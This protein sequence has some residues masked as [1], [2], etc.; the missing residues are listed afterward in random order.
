MKRL[1]VVLCVV[2][3]SLAL[4]AQM[5]QVEFKEFTLDNG[6][7]VILHKDS[8][9]PIVAVSV[10]YHVGS[11]NEQPDRTGFAHFFEHLLFEGTENIE[12]GEYDKYVEKA[13]GTLNANTSNDR[14]YYYEILPSNQLEMGLWLESERMLHA[15]VENKGIETQR[16]VV[17]EERRQ[18]IDNKPYGSI[19]QEAMKRAYTKHHYNWPVIG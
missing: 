15:K 5:N 7:Q 6:L 14:T 10:M 4:N 11:K 1:L 3:F 12:R 2:V 16:E 9:T 18:R 13:G 17:K 19:L 8:S